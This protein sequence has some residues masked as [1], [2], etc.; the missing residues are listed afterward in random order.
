MKFPPFKTNLYWILGIIKDLE[1]KIELCE[2]E[3]E[4][5]YECDWFTK[6]G[7]I[8]SA[9]EAREVVHKLKH[10]IHYRDTTVGLWATDKP[11]KVQDPEKVMFRLEDE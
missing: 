6:K 3:G 4:D 8:I 9:N 2:R 11:E 10:F 1:F 5:P 7:V